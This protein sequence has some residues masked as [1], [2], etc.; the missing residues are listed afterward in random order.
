MFTGST[1]DP[2]FKSFYPP[3]PSKEITLT[4]PLLLVKC[5]FVY[6]ENDRKLGNY[7]SLPIYIYNLTVIIKAA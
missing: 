3:P 4:T 6:G 5:N 1:K 7:L 2:C